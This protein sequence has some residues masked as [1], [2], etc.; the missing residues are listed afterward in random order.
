MSDEKSTDNLSEVQTVKSDG[1]A[2]NRRI[3]TPAAAQAA[4]M[5]IKQ[6]ER[7][8][9]ARY[10]DLMGIYTGFPP[11]PPSRMEELGMSDMPNVN[12]KQFQSKIDQYVNVWRRAT[13]SGMVWY[14][15]KALHDDPREA[16]RRSQYL[17]ECFNRAIARWNRTDFRRT[18][19][20]A[21]R[22]ASR[23]CQMGIFGI[24]ISHFNDPIDWRWEMRPT[25]KVMVPYGTQI[26]MENCPVCFIEDDKISV[27]QLYSMR[28]KPGWNEDAVLWNLYLRTNQTDVP[29]NGSPWSFAQFVN[30]IRDND[31]WLWT[32]E[33]KP[34]RVIHMYVTEFTDDSN[35][36]SITHNIFLD[37]QTTGTLSNDE[38]NEVGKSKDDKR[39]GWLFEKKKAAKQWSE[40]IAV[41][42]DNAGPEMDWHGVKGFGDLIYDNC[43]LNNLMFNRMATSAIIQNMIIFFGT[44]EN[45][46]QKLNQITLSPSCMM[47]PELGSLQQFKVQGDVK[48]AADVFGLGT[49]IL[50]QVSHMEPVT[51]GFGP[52]K[53]ATQENYEQ[54]AKTEVSAL[55]MANYQLT[56]NDALGAEMY[57]RIAQPASKY[58]EV[59]PGGDVAALF[60]KEAKEFGIPEGDLLKVESVL[61]TR[62]GGSG[63][64]G[65]DILKAKEALAIA[66]PGAGQLF[67]RKLIAA[68]MFDP[69]VVEALIEEQAPPPDEED[70]QIHNENLAIQNGQVPMAFG[71][72]PHEKHIKQPSNNDHLS[73]LAGIEEIVNGMLKTGI[74]PNQ[75]Q[76]A[77]KVH[78]IFDAG[79]A[80]VE[81]HVAFMQEM[82]RKGERPSIYEG[83]I[84][85][86]KPV[87]NN[88][89]QL[90]RSFGEL[91]TSAQEAAMQQPQNQDPKM[92]EVQA[93][94]ARK[95]A[96]AEAEIARKDASHQMKLGNQ[97]VQHQART[98]IKTAQAAD[99][100]ELTAQKAAFAL[101]TQRAQKV[102]EIQ[103][104]A[105]T[106]QLNIAVTAA[107][108]EQKLQ[109]QQ[110][111]A[112]AKAEAE[113]TKP[114][115]NEQS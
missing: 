46:R 100:M 71:F 94:I 17:T 13:V 54:M 36:Q 114:K 15:V 14:E 81:Q 16:L 83:F 65:V 72:Q 28:N 19:G 59:H 78:N 76:D 103:E 7:Q 79:I 49:G 12:L 2:P 95:D 90:S 89:R 22:C 48:A 80:H 27:T 106:A 101:Q 53:T 64:M 99:D 3:A 5:S 38:T 74:E 10:G 47:Y 87:L 91:I 96:L 69:Q 32:T 44:D 77:V 6:S 37:T 92:L 9:D 112:D 68:S 8:R 4:Y 63:S 73:I 34:V 88:M 67:A 84:K 82:P 43:H 11:V 39:N 50:D 98:E 93:E 70:V 33:F 18:N 51:Q 108:G 85:E 23:D 24:G 56:G 111:I 61:A 30:W 104:E 45:Q 86:I 26:T 25:R 35:E 31:A 107:E 75:I 41:F 55:Q 1:R 20:Y 60:R 113:R 97:V 105:G 62:Q 58:P 66:T 115:T 40:V 57:R 21:L 110:Q 102:Q 42:A 29:S 52:E 109:Q